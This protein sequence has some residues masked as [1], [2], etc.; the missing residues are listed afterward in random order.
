MTAQEVAVALGS[1]IH[2]I[3][4]LLERGL[5]QGEKVTA[6]I[7]GIK[8]QK[9]LQWAVNPMNWMCF[10][11]ER[12]QDEQIKRLVTRQRERWPDEWWTTGQVGR[13]HGV[14]HM[15]V[16]KQ[17]RQGKL[18]A[19]RWANW[20]VLRSDAVKCHFVTGSGKAGHNWSEAGEM[21]MVLAKAVGMPYSWIAEVQGD[22]NR[23]VDH[24]VRYLLEDERA[25]LQLT[26]AHG[27]WVSVNNGCLW[28]DWR[29]YQNR[30]PGLVRAVGKFLRKEK[31]TVMSRICV[32][33][34][35]HSWLTWF[36]N[37][38]SFAATPEMKAAAAR[39]KY[40][41]SARL[42]ALWSDYALLKK[43]GID[44]FCGVGIA[45]DDG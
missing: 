31:M 35:M 32:R 6:K 5:L 10:K 21:F 39:L 8:R 44:P 1:D 17:I 15:A 19:K 12:V 38:P 34:V 13:Y 14:S 26:R 22:K 4:A 29:K 20:W 36:V 3:V 2:S 27:V 23:A 24:R 33:G 28:A 37:K 30:F 7:W 9:L 40:G 43:W 16:A 18:P 42:D 25:L 11:L 45:R 41:N